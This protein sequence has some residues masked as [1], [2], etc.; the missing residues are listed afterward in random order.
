[1]PCRFETFAPRSRTGRDNRFFNTGRSRVYVYVY[2][3]SLRFF[4]KISRQSIGER[5]VIFYGGAFAGENDTRAPRRR[6]I[7]CRTTA[8]TVCGAR[9]PLKATTLLVIVMAVQTPPGR[10]TV[11]AITTSIISIIIGYTCTP[12]RLDG[13]FVVSPLSQS[14]GRHIDFAPIPP[15]PI[16]TA[17]RSLAGTF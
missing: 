15:P 3:Y 2:I 6:L 11:S 9:A 1:M 7:K 14:G 4:E 5:R 8:V 10:Q 12:G 16:L 17:F 13:V